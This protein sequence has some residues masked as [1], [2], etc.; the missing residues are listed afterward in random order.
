MVKLRMPV[1]LLLLGAI[2]CS[3]GCS[4][5]GTGP[6]DALEPLVGTWRAESLVLTSQANPSLSLDLI[7]EGAVFTI[8]ILGNGQYQ[9]V[10]TAFGQ[11]NAELGTLT[12]SGN[13][14]T[15]EPSSQGG[16]TTVGTFSF[17]G[18]ALILDGETS[19][20]FNQDGITENALAHFRLV[21]H[22]I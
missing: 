2:L 1:I 11:T 4:D 9:A 20:D 10:L 5:D 22:E 13:Q 16:A 21:P 14:I 18:E 12:V 15:M 8:S 6:V 19:Y 7:Q 3:G 17:S